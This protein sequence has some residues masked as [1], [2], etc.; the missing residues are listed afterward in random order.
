MAISLSREF[1]ADH[2]GAELL[3][4]G[5]S[6]ARALEKIEAYAKQVPMNVAPAQ[7]TAYIVNPLTGRQVQFAN[8]FR[9]HPP[10]AERVAR[11]RHL[12]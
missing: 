5:E 1:E 11:L 8:L 9:T 3:G 10:T 12:A 4:S 7:A 6:L 2:S